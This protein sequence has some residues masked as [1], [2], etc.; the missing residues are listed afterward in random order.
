MAYINQE[1]LER[2]ISREELTRL[3]DDSNNGSVNPTVLDEAINVASNEFDNY[4]RDIYDTLQFP[5]PLPDML[6]QI[7]V[8]ITIYNLYKRR[9]RLDMPESITKIYE[10]AID[11]LSKI[12]RGEIQLTL[13]KKSTAGFIKINKT[14]SDRLF[15]RE[16]LDKL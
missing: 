8:D 2:Y 15:S 10:T 12:S 3:T 7:I 14:D 13:P 16:E 5:F 4:L 6:T 9:Y 11:K 1:I